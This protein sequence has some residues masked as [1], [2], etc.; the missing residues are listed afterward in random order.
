M[1]AAVVA[2]AL[3]L[4]FRAPL[5]PP[6]PFER[7]PQQGIHY[8]PALELPWRDRSDPWVELQ[9]WAE[10][11]TPVDALFLTPPDIEG[12]RSFSRRS[13]FVDW[14]QGTLSLFHPAFGSEWQERMRLLAP[15]RLDPWPIRNLARNY[16]ALTAAELQDLV[17]RF[18]ITHVVVRQPRALGLPLVYENAAFRVYAT[19]RAGGITM[20]PGT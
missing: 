2:L 7:G 16:D 17:T 13:H 14:K 20:A 8:A 6:L 18:A 11:S 12:F 9:R 3:L 19:Q 10:A 1:A 5:L 15:R 4:W